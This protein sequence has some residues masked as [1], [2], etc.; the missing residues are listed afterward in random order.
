MHLRFFEDSLTLRRFNGKGIEGALCESSGI[1]GA[2][3]PTVLCILWPDEAWA[4]Q[5]HDSPEGYIVHQMAHGFFFVAMGV[6]T[7]WLRSTGLVRDQGWRHIQWACLL[8]AAWNL[9]DRRQVRTRRLPGTDRLS[10]PR[11]RKMF[12]F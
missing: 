2:V 5:V 9:K 8:F 4:L 11:S 7:Y 6:H 3:V 10:T 12:A 1:T